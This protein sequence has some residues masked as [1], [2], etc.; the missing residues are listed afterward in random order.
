MADLY[1]AVRDAAN[2]LDEHNGADR[3]EL[4]GRILKIGDPLTPSTKTSS[5]T[6][7]A[8]RKRGL[9]LRV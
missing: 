8:P 5:K 3:A 1:T 2:W 7:K 4:A 9:D 6:V